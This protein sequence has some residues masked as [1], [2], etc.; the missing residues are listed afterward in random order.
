MAEVLHVLARNGTS[1]ERKTLE[2]SKRAKFKRK[3]FQCNDYILVGHTY[4]DP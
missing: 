2:M 4:L 3:I 1:L